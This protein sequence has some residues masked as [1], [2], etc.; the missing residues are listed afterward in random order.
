[1]PGTKLF[2][3]LKGEVL[4]S[5]LPFDPAIDNILQLDLSA[6]NKELTP[7][8]FSETNLFS[9]YI[10]QALSEK[11]ALY[12]LGGYNELREVYGRSIVFNNSAGKE[13]RRLHLG[14]DIWGNA[15][16]PVSSPLPGIVHSFADNAN[17]GDY[18]NTIIITHN[19][20]G[21]IFYILYGHLSSASLEGL[22]VG[23]KIKK[24]DV[25]GTFGIPLEN[26]HWPPHLHFQV[27]IDVGNHFGDYP[28]VCAVSEK[29]EWLINSPDPDSL[30]QLNRYLK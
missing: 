4:H 1:M 2:H 5:V 11:D 16:T 9:K 15:G 23:K 26:G 18:G 29:E 24:G 22:S 28:G 3:L 30:L 21:Y 27:I 12:G 14:T 8:V 7:E 13:P 6:A 25:F 19:I 10:T 17:Y 20:N